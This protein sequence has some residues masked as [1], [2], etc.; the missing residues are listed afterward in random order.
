MGNARQPH[1]GKAALLAGRPNE[2]PAAS[3]PCP[4]TGGEHSIEGDSP[5]YADIQVAMAECMLDLGAN[6]RAQ[7][8][9]AQ[10]TAIHASHARLAEPIGASEAFAARMP[11]D[12]RN[13]AH[14]VGTH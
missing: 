7:D 13:T 2:A 10:A 14:F 4:R 1:F 9:F 3:S 12:P 6:R 8:L 5:Q 11:A